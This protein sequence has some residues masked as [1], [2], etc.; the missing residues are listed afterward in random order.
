MSHRRVFGGS[1]ALFTNGSGRYGGGS[2]FRSSGRALNRG[3]PFA[4]PRTR[5][6]GASTVSTRRSCHG[7]GRSGAT[8]A[9]WGGFRYRTHWISHGGSFRRPRVYS[10]RR[11]YTPSTQ[12]GGSRRRSTAIVSSGAGAYQSCGGGLVMKART[13]S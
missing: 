12:N 7:L 9:G 11:Y 10:G 5:W 1:G 2:M 4:S 13:A 8:D 6:S 3:S